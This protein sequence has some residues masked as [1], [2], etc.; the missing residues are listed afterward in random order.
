MLECCWTPIDE[1]VGTWFCFFHPFFP[2]YSALHYTELAPNWHRFPLISINLAL[3][4]SINGPQVIVSTLA[5]H[6]RVQ[7]PGFSFLLHSLSLSLAS[8]R[9]REVDWPLLAGRP[10]SINHIHLTRDLSNFNLGCGGDRICT[11]KKSGSSAEY[12]MIF[13]VRHS[14]LICGA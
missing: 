1:K 6:T 8:P 12:L 14:I 5:Q 13:F 3:P 7:F 10:G 2:L 9:G 11:F 4:I